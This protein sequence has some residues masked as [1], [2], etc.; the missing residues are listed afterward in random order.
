MVYQRITDYEVRAIFEVY[1]RKLS[2]KAPGIG[3]PFQ[4]PDA[5]AQDGG[6]DPGWDQPEAG[7]RE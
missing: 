2:G 6:S 3:D 4:S 1:L 7:R 5:G